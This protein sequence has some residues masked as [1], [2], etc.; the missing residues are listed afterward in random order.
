MELGYVC[1]HLLLATSACHNPHATQ[2]PSD[3]DGILLG[4]V[5]L[6]GRRFLDCSDDPDL[7]A[8]KVHSF[9]KFLKRSFS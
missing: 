6:P 8:I 9:A 1:S 2:Q 5:T 7:Q 3:H 4:R